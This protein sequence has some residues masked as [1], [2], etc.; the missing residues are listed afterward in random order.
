MKK[1]VT[2]SM[3]YN[4]IQCPHR[5]T[6][7]VFENPA[8]KDP[9]NPFVQLLWEKGNAF[10]KEVIDGLGIP[11][12][13]LHE[14]YGEEKK[15]RTL[16]AIA[17]GDELIY[18]GRITI[19]DLVGEPDLLRKQAGGYI[20]GDIKSG[21]GE[22]GGSE[23]EDGRPKKHY[24]VQLALYTDIIER[25]GFAAGRAPFVWDVHGRE[26]V[27]DLDAPQGSRTPRS[28]WDEYEAA[29]ETV[30]C[31][32]DQT[33]S[34][35]PAYGGTCKLCHWY[36]ACLRRLEKADDLTLIP[37]LGRSKRDT[38]MNHLSTV[39]DLADADVETLIR[40]KKTDF[41]GIGPDTLR[42]FQ[43]RAKLQKKPGAQPYVK[44]PLKLPESDMELFFDIETDPMRDVCYLHGFTERRN[45]DNRTER[46]VPF[47]AEE[48]SEQEEEKAFAA[49][50]AYIQHSQPCAI[51][52]YSAYER[53]IW[54]KLQKKYPH[55]M[56]VEAIEDLFDPAYAVDL[57][58]HVVR[59]KTEWPTRDFSIKTLASFLGFSWRDPNPSGAASIEWYHRWTESGDPEIRQ[60]IL[61]YNEDDCVAT[62]V[63]LDGIRKLSVQ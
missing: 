18:S 16:E 32:L 11:C 42:K 23:D 43:N 20:A 21:A 37:E 3:L 2:A 31:L 9:V 48:P 51:Y 25:L 41:P 63:L 8:L 27:Y 1:L 39:L 28:L 35:L 17:R 10:E 5:V 53:T 15:R 30:R 6:M 49:A 44:E 24:A 22:E 52:Y 59:P 12:T 61:D 46:Y 4:L 57:Y 38:M 33:G 54:R 26:V 19:G 34:T 45:G 14:Y 7:D 36:S 56:T 50:W 29:L 60:R 13:D 47:L 62:R 40:G 58:H 55:V